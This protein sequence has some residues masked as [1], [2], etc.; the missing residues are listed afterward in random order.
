MISS[1]RQQPIRNCS[2]LH[3]INCSSMMMRRNQ[4]RKMSRITHKYSHKRSTT[5]NNSIH[6]LRNFIVCIIFLSIVPYK[7]ITNSWTRI[8]LNTYRNSIILS[9]TS[10]F[11]KQSNPTCLS[12]NCNMS[13]LR[14]TAA[15]LIHDTL[16]FRD[17]KHLR[18]VRFRILMAVTVKISI[19]RNVTACRSVG[20]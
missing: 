14:P 3:P 1:V 7:I 11:T 9:H 17:P 18:Q 16:C 6:R 8:N 10:P 19:L 20:T 2:S 5:R 12:S 13:T 15:M 4:G